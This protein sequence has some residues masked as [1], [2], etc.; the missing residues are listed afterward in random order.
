MSMLFNQKHLNLSVS[1]VIIAKLLVKLI[2]FSSFQMKHS[3]ILLF[4][5]FVIQYGNDQLLFLFLGGLILF[6]LDYMNVTVI[7]NKKLVLI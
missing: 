3:V 4:I 7:G 6:V 2:I 1:S 5:L